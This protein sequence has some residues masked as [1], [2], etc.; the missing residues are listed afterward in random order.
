VKAYRFSVSWPRVPPPRNR[1]LESERSGS[2]NRLIDELRGNGVEPFCTLFHWDLPELFR[3]T[4]GVGSH[5][6]SREI[7]D[8]ACY[9]SLELSDRVRHFF[10]VNEFAS[11]IDLGY[12]DG[13]TCL[14][15]LSHLSLRISAHRRTR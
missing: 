10:T 2:Y 5:G 1:Q 9:V 14:D 7:A 6:P 8:Y 13:L 11:F 4:I 3:P 12:R 15:L